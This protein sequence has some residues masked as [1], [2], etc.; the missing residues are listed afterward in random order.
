MAETHGKFEEAFQNNPAAAQQI[1]HIITSHEGL[2]QQDEKNKEKIYR[3]SE[4]EIIYLPDP[5]AAGVALF[6]AEGYE[7]T[8]TQDF[9]ARMFSFFRNKRNQAQ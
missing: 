8:H 4:V 5:M 3:P 6:V 1:Y 2:Y 7:N 9:Y